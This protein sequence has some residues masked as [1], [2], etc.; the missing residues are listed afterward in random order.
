MRRIQ[1]RGGLSVDDGI[2]RTGGVC[3]LATLNNKI[4]GFKE[5]HE[6]IISDGD[7]K[8]AVMVLPTNEE[9]MIVKDTF[10]KVIG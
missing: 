7:S 6:G 9:I 8:I 3:A 10:N 2:V 1:S 4:A 5:L